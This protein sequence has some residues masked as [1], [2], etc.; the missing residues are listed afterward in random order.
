MFT[1]AHLSD[2]HLAPLPRPDLHHLLSK[3]FLGYVNWQRRKGQH[4]RDVLDQVT[5][6]ML[7]RNPTHIAVTGDLVNIALPEEFRLARRWLDGFQR[8]AEHVSVVPGNH[9]A[10]SPFVNDPRIRHWRPYMVSN[11]QA[12]PFADGW[13]RDFPYLRI[14][15]DIALIGLTSAR[16]TFPG[17]A[18][19]WLGPKQIRRAAALLDRLGKA[20]LCRIVMIHHPPLP[21]QTGQ[22]RGLHDA[23]M[24]KAALVEH[25]AE[26]VLHGHNHRTMGT[27]LETRSGPLPVIGASSASLLTAEPDKCASYN[28]FG[29]AG[30]ENGR[31]R[32]SLN[33]RS[34]DESGNLQDRETDLSRL[35]AH[36]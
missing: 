15:G 34:L 32:I 3:R 1:L 17:M 11:E 9:D 14:F 35:P 21:G 36:H 7:A 26:L 29:I 19:G 27:L 33:R 4:R 23:R 25:G 28:L 24:F 16:P 31:W 2:I 10:Y 8:E 6:D 18:S 20:G 5:E 12:A 22:L 13:T 30:A